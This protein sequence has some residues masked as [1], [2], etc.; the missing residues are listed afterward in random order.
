MIKP[1]LQAQRFMLP[2]VYSSKHS[3]NI[4]LNHGK[5]GAFEIWSSF[6]RSATHETGFIVRYQPQVRLLLTDV[7]RPGW[8]S[9]GVFKP[10]ASPE[11]CR[12]HPTHE[13]LSPFELE[14]AL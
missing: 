14:P 1:K 5:S 13:G 11:A 2:N 7:F 12:K 8:L 6:G 10:A 4:L 9:N 3:L